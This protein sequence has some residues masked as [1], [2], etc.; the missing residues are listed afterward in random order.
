MPNTE[1]DA[2]DHDF[3]GSS[4]GTEAHQTTTLAC[5]KCGVGQTVDIRYLGVQRVGVDLTIFPARGSRTI[6]RD[7]VRFFMLSYESACQE[8]A[9][10]GNVVIRGTPVIPL[11]EGL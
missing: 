6:S 11:A 9:S 5:R 1:C 4:D 10:N 2:A 7:M 8:V 3:D